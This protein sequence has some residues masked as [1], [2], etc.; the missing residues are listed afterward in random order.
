MW[1]WVWKIVKWILISLLW[2]AIWGWV[3]QWFSK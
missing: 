3:K 1:R 2:E